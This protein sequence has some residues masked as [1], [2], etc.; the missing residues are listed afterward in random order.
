MAK[1][2]KRR[3]DCGGEQKQGPKRRLPGDGDKRGV[4]VTAAT[5][6]TTG[7]I[8]LPDF[9]LRLLRVQTRHVVFRQRNRQL[10]DQPIA[11][12]IPRRLRF[13]VV[14]LRSG[15]DAALEVE[16]T[17]RCKHSVELVKSRSA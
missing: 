7:N 16:S 12:P 10:P 14:L 1:R 11:Q 15:Q 5:K 13:G 17:Q 6:A 2:E 9:L 3:G 4:P 8:E